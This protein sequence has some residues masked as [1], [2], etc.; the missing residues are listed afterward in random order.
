MT[1][2]NLAKPDSQATFCS[3]A[4]V[5]T[6][7]TDTIGFMGTLSVTNCTF[8]GTTG[9][10]DMMIDL[11][12]GTGSTTPGSVSFSYATT[13]GAVNDPGITQVSPSSAPV[14]TSVT[15]SGT[16]FA[17][18]ANNY[19][20]S[21]NGITA[22]PVVRTLT[23]LT[24]IVP[25]GAT[26]GPL[27]VTD[28]T[29]SSIY[30]VNGGFTVTGTTGGGTGPSGTVTTQMGGSRQGNP[31]TLSTSVSLV[32]G[33]LFNW[34]GDGIGGVAGLS[35]PYGVTTDGTNLFVADTRN[36]LIRKVVLST[37]AVTTIAGGGSGY[38]QACCSLVY[39]KP[40][41]LNGTGLAASFNKPTWIT[42]DGT[43][44]YVT[45]QGNFKIRKIEIATGIVTTFAGTGISGIGDGSGIAAQFSTLGGITTDGTNL[46]VVD[47]GRIRKVAIDTG[48]VTT[49]ILKSDIGTAVTL[50][51]VGIT[52]DGTNLYVTEGSL[53]STIR[54][55]EISTGVTTVLAGGNPAATQ[56]QDM[57]GIGTEASFCRLRGITTDG[58]NL[59]VAGNDSG[60]GVG[61]W[62]AVV[63][64]VVI[65]TGQTT[66][67]AG[68]ASQW[69]TNGV[70][71][72][73]GFRSLKG[74][75]TDGVSLFVVDDNRI[76]KIQ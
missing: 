55:I 13:G 45:D 1:K 51:G 16:N 71:T 4:A 27:T 40:G 29:T 9:Q 44:L 42:T 75:T 69:D 33:S 31:L 10:I 3:D 11:G 66:T 64:K 37:Y 22:T 65:A 63:R 73:A 34:N 50:S 56:C 62:T 12:V 52:T 49:P 21:F 26:T 32:A 41:A 6:A 20:V 25:T 48:Y 60:Y 47:A 23:Q 5:H 36:N 35:A 54:K 59:Y 70:G 18:P 68:G 30:T 74:I 38:N 19:S 53:A 2:L 7:L 17:Q 28:L 72:S 46:Y 67:L 76:R 58:V 14:G 39:A 15:I 8:N 43:N 61:N 57:D 24:V